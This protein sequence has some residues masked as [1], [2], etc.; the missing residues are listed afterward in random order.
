MSAPPSTYEE[1]TALRDIVQE[2][3]LVKRN[4][5][6]TIE[7]RLCA[8]LTFLSGLL[9]TGSLLKRRRDG[10]WILRKDSEGYY[11][12][13]VHTTLPILAVL[14]AILDV[15]AVLFME[16]NLNR[17]I[18]PAPVILQLLAYQALQLFA[19]VKIW[20][21]LYALLSSRLHRRTTNAGGNS[22]RTR[23]LISPTIFNTFILTTITAVSLG[24]TPLITLL[25]LSIHKYRNQFSHCDLL[26]QQAAD[27]S[28]ING[29]DPTL[30]NE[31]A[32]QAIL[33][34]HILKDEGAKE[35]GFFQTYL[36]LIICWMS[37]NMLLFS[38]SSAFLL[39]LLQ[40]QKKFLS[41]ALKNRQ[42]L[43]KIQ[44][45]KQEKKN[46][47]K[48]FN[49]WDFRDENGSENTTRFDP[50]T[51]KSWIDFAREDDMMNDEAFW[52]RLDALSQQVRSSRAE[53][54]DALVG[55]KSKDGH[56]IAPIDDATL[57]MHC[58]TITRYWYSTIG[59][60]F[61]GI[62][63]FSSY[64]VMACRL[65]IK[66][67]SENQQLIEAFIWSNWIWGGGPGLV[68]GIV[69][70]AVAFSPTSLLPQ[71]SKT[72]NISPSTAERKLTSSDA[73]AP[74]QED[75]GKKSLKS[76]ST[77][78]RPST[79]SQK[80]DTNFSV[81]VRQSSISSSIFSYATANLEHTSPGMNLE[82][83]RGKSDSPNS[84]N[85]V[86]MEWIGHLK[87]IQDLRQN[88]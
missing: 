36:T 25:S 32:T 24:Q 46:R 86:E 17:P 18:G 73:F 10:M 7:L 83:I 37:F 23:T 53:L 16:R 48:N 1:W 67:P 34:F 31:P 62:G 88:N 30:N 39:H 65:L 12:P 68:L 77:W 76:R 43:Q 54:I 6:E 44:G 38:V 35:R 61:V 87:A 49:S 75:D 74:G 14:Y 51:W 29:G 8:A 81:P 41:S 64:L 15:S 78:K 79:E 19:S 42:I 50:R 20:A 66:R 69:A 57:E 33:N 27:M 28:I 52:G 5:T 2:F 45:G 84:D 11:Q 13:N 9:Y 71:S 85:Q 72:T 70:C 59:Q 60:T 4:P 82:T 21:I 3:A 56:V 58:T 26:M 80:S 55:G 47:R 40:S 63:M 22:S